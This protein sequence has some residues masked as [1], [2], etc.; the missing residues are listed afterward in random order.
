MNDLTSFE[1]LLTLRSGEKITALEKGACAENTPSGAAL[2][3]LS[4]L[5]IS[6]IVYNISCKIDQ[7]MNIY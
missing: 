5:N 7:I 6:N 1:T 2:S 3:S 4:I